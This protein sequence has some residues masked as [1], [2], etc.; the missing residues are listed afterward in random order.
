LKRYRETNKLNEV[1]KTD[2]VSTGSSGD[3]RRVFPVLIAGAAKYIGENTGQQ[4]NVELYED[5]KE[6]LEI[7]GI[8]LEQKMK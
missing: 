6:V 5:S 4:V 2:I 8:Q 3:L 7:K 1:W